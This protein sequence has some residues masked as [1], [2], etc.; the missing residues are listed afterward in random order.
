MKN[1]TTIFLLA[2]SFHCM[3]Q[4][5]LPEG[6]IWHYT[7]MEFGLPANVSEMSIIGDTLIQGK[8]CSILQRNLTTCDNRPIFD[9]MYKSDDKLFYYDFV[10][11]TFQL[12]CDFSA[13]PGDVYSIPIWPGMENLSESDSL[14]VRVD[15]VRTAELSNTSLDYF[16]VSYG[17]VRADTIYYHTWPRGE[18]YEDI[19][20]AFSFFHFPENGFCDGLHSSRLRCLF[21]PDFGEDRFITG[22][23]VCDSLSSNFN[24]V[25]NDKIDVYPNPTRDQITIDTKENSDFT[26]EIFSIYGEKVESTSFNNQSSI[27]L[28]VDHLDS[29]IYLA[30]IRNLRNSMTARRNIVIQE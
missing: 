29:G 14:Y 27:S 9:Y 18:Y 28:L 25:E 8:S 6:M 2:C 13:G 21:H 10:K 1:I 19:G 7:N 22:D 12:L 16:Y 30:I 23:A 26:I 20:S 4:N 5:W 3:S 24:I 15:S 11:E 17:R